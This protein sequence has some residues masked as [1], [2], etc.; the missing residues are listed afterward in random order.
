MNVEGYVQSHHLSASCLSCVS[1]CPRRYFYMYGQSLWKQSTV[2][3]LEFG[4]AIHAGLAP[5]YANDL[6]SAMA[7]FKAVWGERDELGDDKRSTSRALV[8]FKAFSSNHRPGV[9]LYTIVKPLSQLPVDDLVSENELPFALD[10]GLDIPL[11]GRIDAIGKHRDDQSVWAVEYKGQPLDAMVVTPF[12]LMKMGDLVVG[13]LVVGSDGMPTSIEAIHPL[14]KKP[15]YEITFSD[16][17]STQCTDDHLWTV[18]YRSSGEKVVSKTMEMK[19]IRSTYNRS[20]TYWIPSISPVLFQEQPVPLP[21]YLLGVGLGDGDFSASIRVST[22]DEEIITRIRREWQIGEVGTDKRNG[23]HM[24]VALDTAKILRSLGLDGVKSK[25]KFIPSCYLYN[26]EDVRLKVLQGLMDTDGSV[27][28]RGTPLFTT[29]SPA[30]AEGV[31]FIVES[32]GGVCRVHAYPAMLRGVCYGAMFHCQMNL[33]DRERVFLLLRKRDKVTKVEDGVQNKWKRRIVRIEYV[34]E[35]E[36]QCIKVGN[37]DGLYATDSFILTHNTTSELS[38]RFMVGFSLSPQVLAYTLALKANNPM[39]ELEVKGCIVEAIQSS[40][41]KIDTLALPVYVRDHSLKAFVEWVK[42]EY[43][44]I[45]RCEQAGEWPQNFQA[46]TPYS[47]FGMPGYTCDFQPLC[48]VEDWAMLRSMFE[49]RPRKEFV[50]HATTSQS[51]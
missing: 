49:V 13:D 45:R 37:K 34:G 47:G 31:K 38:T 35:K 3:A 33:P 23:M 27:T 15:T 6:A 32:L 28:N 9:S 41:Y 40:K 50:L 29:T 48:M 19:H 26:T 44:M 43:A 20:R 39:P 22:G 18:Y 7:K 2:P 17:S 16:G 1:R 12:G 36:C 30:L 5:C 24:F 46:C 8:M 21:P 14:G 4:Q 42:W 25:D 11:V 10:V 51:P